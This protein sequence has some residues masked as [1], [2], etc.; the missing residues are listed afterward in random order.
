MLQ[1][2]VSTGN[3]VTHFDQPIICTLQSF[4]AASNILVGHIAAQLVNLKK[5]NLKLI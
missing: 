1:L 5:S 4:L 3:I 2:K